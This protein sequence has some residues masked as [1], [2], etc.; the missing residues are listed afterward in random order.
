M[1]IKLSIFITMLFIS[2]LAIAGATNCIDV[3]WNEGRYDNDGQTL[4]NNCSRKVEVMWCHNNDERKYRK[5]RCG[6]DGRYY[7]KHVVLQAGEIKSNQ[8]TLPPSGRI[9]YG[10]CYG[11]YGSIDDKTSSSSSFNCR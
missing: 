4:E 5:S 8:Y 11:G 1:K 10:A 2:Q 9:S 6:R 7:Q 3:G